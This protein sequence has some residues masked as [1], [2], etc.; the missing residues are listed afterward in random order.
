MDQKRMI[1]I[2]AGIFVAGFLVCGG[3]V[4]LLKGLAGGKDTRT[5]AKAPT[6]PVTTPPRS[7][8]P[9]TVPKATVPA[10]PTA[11]V[12]PKTGGMP[13]E[14]ELRQLVT[15]TFLDLDKGLKTK[16]FTAFHARLARPFQKDKTPK[17]LQ[18]TFQNFID[19]K[20]DFSPIKEVAPKFDPAPALGADG[21]LTLSGHFPAK[22]LRLGFKLQYVFEAP[23]WKLLGWG[24]DVN[25]E[26]TVPMD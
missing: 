10:P 14:A 17:D 5:Q 23:D 21:V 15:A 19:G 1:L 12:V 3:G 18:A 2:G 24:L 11:P 8:A 16:D 26:R 7:T 9:A 13:T 25:Q 4:L 6:Q 20:A 22:G